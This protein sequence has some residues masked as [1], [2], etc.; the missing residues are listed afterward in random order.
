MGL[1]QGLSEGAVKCQRGPL[2]T[3]P[4][5]SIPQKALT[6]TIIGKR[7]QYLVTQ[8][9]PQGTPLHEAAQDTTA[10][11]PPEQVMSEKESTGSRPKLQ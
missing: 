1:A 9:P 8:T 7:T 10:G 6:R 5:R 11:F 3:A 4:G 2:L